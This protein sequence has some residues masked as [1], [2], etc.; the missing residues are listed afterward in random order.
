MR[1]VD[2]F[3][4]KVKR[5]ETPFYRGIKEAV[6][7]AERLSVP[8]PRFIMPALRIVYDLHF[9]AFRVA[10]KLIGMFY[11]E[12]LFRS[13]CTSVGKGLYLH[14]LPAI[15]AG[16][17]VHFGDDVRISG[18]L[19]I[20][21]GRVFDQPRLV[22]G[23]NVYLAHQVTFDVAREI[24]VED[25]AWLA[26]GTS[27][28]DNDGHPVDL[29]LRLAGLP[30]RPEEV[31]PVRICRNAWIGRGCRIMKGVTI[32]E[33][34]VVGAGSVVLSD[35]PPFALAIG[36]PARVIRVLSSPPKTPQ[37][38]SDVAAASSA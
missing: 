36:Y 17:E 9:L 35:I 22:V 11:S 37:R 32:G 21:A 1:D 8:V 25:G 4:L 6:K 14:K 33:G 18:A 19:R 3:V 10:R 24:I 23:N 12:P 16:M 7:R 15:S 31:K 34:V 26:A 38:Y 13:R 20:T 2:A 28:C 30:P 29:E 27:V 5:A